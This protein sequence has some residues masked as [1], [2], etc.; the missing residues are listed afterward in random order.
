VEL[1]Q[2]LE[3]N[4]GWIGLLNWPRAIGF[5]SLIGSLGL[6]YS[7]ERVQYGQLELEVLVRHLA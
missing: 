3:L 6:E 5:N 2:R 7:C 1:S 4:D